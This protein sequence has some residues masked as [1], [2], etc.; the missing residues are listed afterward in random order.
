MKLIMFCSDSGQD[1][2]F[3]LTKT[4][5]TPAS[6]TYWVDGNPSGYRWWGASDPNQFVTCIRYTQ[7]GFK[8]KE[9]DDDYRF[10]CKMMAS[11]QQP[12]YAVDMFSSCSCLYNNNVRVSLFLFQRISVH[13]RATI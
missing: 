5:A 10:T 8:D 7:T 12:L 1:Y 4:T 13:C 11:K 6:S 3:G 9:C 2:W